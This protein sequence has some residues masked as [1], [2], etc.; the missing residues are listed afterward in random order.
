MYSSRMKL[1]GHA[2]KM[3]TWSFQYEVLFIPIFYR[4]VDFVATYSIISKF[5][6]NIEYRK[7]EILSKNM[8]FH[9]IKISN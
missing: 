9:I 5:V 4:H 8:K 7:D 2:C 1:Y 3:Y 6:S